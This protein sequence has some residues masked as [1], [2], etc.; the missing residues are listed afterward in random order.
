MI[1][2]HIEKEKYEEVIKLIFLVYIIYVIF[3]SLILAGAERGKI[4]ALSHSCI[5]MSSAVLGIILA[6][7]ISTPLAIHICNNMV[8]KKWETILAG[9]ECLTDAFNYYQNILPQLGWLATAATKY[10][11]STAY[12]LTDYDA[13]GGK[14]LNDTIIDMLKTPLYELLT[15][16]IFII[17]YIVAVS[18]SV[19]IL[20]QIFKPRHK[21]SSDIIGFNIIGRTSGMIIYATLCIIL[22]KILWLTRCFLSNSY[23]TDKLLNYKL[24][25]WIVYL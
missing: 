18:V 6:K 1:L 9:E 13:L 12:M 5:G 25:H 20:I 19:V 8:I 16:A 10:D 11:S 4:K 17:V 23:F 15:N 14:S 22:F 2:Y 3:G 21:P 7:F 24:L